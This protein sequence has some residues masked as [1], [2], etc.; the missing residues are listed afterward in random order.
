MNEMLEVQNDP[1]SYNPYTTSIGMDCARDSP[2]VASI[3]M[4]CSREILANK[5]KNYGLF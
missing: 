4:D 1:N 3:A 5:K 2:Y